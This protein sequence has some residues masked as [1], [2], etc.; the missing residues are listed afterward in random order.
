MLCTNV[1][2]VNDDAIMTVTHDILNSHLNSCLKPTTTFQMSPVPAMENS[3]WQ[4]QTTLILDSF[5]LCYTWPPHLSWL[6]NSSSSSA[7][8]A[9]CLK[10]PKHLK[11]T[12]S[13]CTEIYRITWQWL[14]HKVWRCHKSFW[15]ATPPCCQFGWTASWAQRGSF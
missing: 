6:A 5:R 10:P 2:Y 9:G 15:Q 11:E 1:N 7:C 13:P 3:W 8:V 12:V 4:W 14:I